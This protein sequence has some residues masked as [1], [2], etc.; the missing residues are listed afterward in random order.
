MSA[1]VRST[2][3]APRG[4]VIELAE[5]ILLLERQGQYSATQTNA[6]L[7]ILMGYPILVDDLTLPL[8]WGAVLSLAR[9]YALSC[10]SATYLELALRRNLPLAAIDTSLTRAATAAGVSLYVP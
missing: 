2:A 1:L 4:F 10:R 3:I 9:T 8:A 6:E 7:A 5:E